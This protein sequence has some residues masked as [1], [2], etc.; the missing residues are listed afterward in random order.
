M[1]T[2]SIIDHLV[3]AVRSLEDGVAYITE[4]LG[5]LPVPGG[6]HPRMGTHNALVRLG[7]TT[8]L[9]VIAANPGA[10]TPQRARWFGLDHRAGLCAATADHLG[11]ADD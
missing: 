1:G 2:R 4:Q 11:R 10:A 9:E 8:Y 5:V 3:I 7:D 6:E